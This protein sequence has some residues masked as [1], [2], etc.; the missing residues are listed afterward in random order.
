MK[1]GPP[2]AF[3]WVM[4]AEMLVFM[5]VG[6]VGSLWLT[7]VYF[8]SVGVL[9]ILFAGREVELT[10]EGIIL[11]W[12]YPRLFKTLIPFEEIIDII[13]VAS[14]RY[15]VMARYL[16]ETLIGPLG[17]ILVGIVFFFYGKYPAI[18]LFWIVW[19]FSALVGFVFSR[20]DKNTAIMAFYT[21]LVFLALVSYLK[22]GTDVLFPFVAS[23]AMVGGL[24]WEGD[25]WDRSMILLVTENGVYTL[26]YSSRKEILPLMSR[27][28]EGNES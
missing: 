27:L 8:L 3:W 18:G 19:G 9:S 4:L 7:A 28:G 16:P 12:G 26:N 6:L 14:S 21:V 5:V 23:G 24:M 17:T 1:A 20:G 2:R 13:D 10:E 22:M 15:L 25:L 11:S